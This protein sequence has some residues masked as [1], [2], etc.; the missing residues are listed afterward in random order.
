MS[1][2][3][4]RF[5]LG[6]VSLKKK[7][8]NDVFRGNF[9]MHATPNSRNKQITA[10]NS[11]LKNSLCLI[12]EK[13]PRASVVKKGLEEI[14]GNILID[15]ERSGKLENLKGAMKTTLLKQRY[16]YHTHCN[17]VLNPK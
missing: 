13:H 14:I 16:C 3:V 2:T 15:L 11:F 9:G 5:L 6:C 1:A 8:R 12:C 4:R 10:K 7:H 17:K